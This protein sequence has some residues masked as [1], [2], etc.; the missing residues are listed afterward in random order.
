VCWCWRLV[1]KIAAFAQTPTPNL[2][3]L[4]ALAWYGRLQERHVEPGSRSVWTHA[5]VM[6]QAGRKPWG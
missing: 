5:R 6:E 4:P 1:W 3:R 2:T